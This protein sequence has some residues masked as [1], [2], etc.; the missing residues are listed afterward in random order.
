MVT[1]VDGTIT[2]LT[3]NKEAG[4][5]TVP[6]ISSSWLEGTKVRPVYVPI[7]AFAE[8]AIPKIHGQLWGSVAIQ[9]IFREVF[10]SAARRPFITAA[11]DSDQTIDLNSNVTVRMTA[12][13]ADGSALENCVATVDIGG[14]KTK[15]P[16][17]PTAM[18]HGDRRAEVS[19]KRAGIKH[20]IGSDM[21][22][23]E[24]TFTWNG[25][26]QVVPVIIRSV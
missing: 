20:N 17:D 7:G 4:D 26:T 16:F 1:L 24:I 18:L 23:F 5:G 2:W 3:A 6:F 11:A 8:G 19:I 15:V 13:A 25:G 21:F 22:R 9:Q 14:K 10:G 12:L